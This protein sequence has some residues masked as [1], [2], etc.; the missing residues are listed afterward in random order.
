M[1]ERDDFENEKR[2][3]LT[4]QAQSQSLTRAAKEFVEQTHIHRHTYQWT[5]MGLPIIQMPGDVMAMQEI[6]WAAKPDL[7]IETGIAWGGSTLFYASLL[8]MIGKG[9]VVAVD[10]TI[11]DHNRKTITDNR[12]AH[13]MTLIEG[14]SIDPRIVA[15]IQAMVQPGMSVMVVLDSNHT[16]DH[17]LGELRAFAPLASVGNYVVVFDTLIETCA[18]DPSLE[19]PWGKGNNPYTAIDAFLAEDDRFQRDVD[20]DTK[21][22]ASYAPG[23]Y[24]RRV[25]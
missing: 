9:H 1:F 11:P 4:R 5:W 12:F 19:R 10:R 23:G 21:V 20:C 6:V 17:V 14:S 15:D 24:V 2:D 3:W 7:I 18:T 25:R 22:L 8:E 13:R 16:H